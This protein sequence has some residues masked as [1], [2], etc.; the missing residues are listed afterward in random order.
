MSA[1]FAKKIGGTYFRYSDDILVIAPIS[2][3]DA[4]FLEKDIRYAITTYG[5]GLL[6]KEEKSAI[7]K[8]VQTGHRQTVTVIKATDKNGKPTLNKPFE[9]LGFRYDGRQVYIRDKTMSNLHRKIASVSQAMAIRLVKRY[10]GKAVSDI[11]GLVD[12]EKFVQ[13]FGP[14]EDFRSKSDDYRS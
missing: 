5:K 11:L 10:Q 13:A 7:H 6:I 4:I 12:F 3:A 14:V 8:F 9:Y 2:E 1:I